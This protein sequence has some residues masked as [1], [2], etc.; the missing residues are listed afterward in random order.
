MFACGTGNLELWL[1]EVM[2]SSPR[3]LLESFFIRVLLRVPAML[4]SRPAIQPVQLERA[5]VT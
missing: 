5:P 4:P 2:R 1:P 3:V